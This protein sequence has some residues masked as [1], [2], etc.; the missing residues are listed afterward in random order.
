M[1]KIVVLAFFLLALLF[2]ACASAEPEWVFPENDENVRFFVL[3]ASSDDKNM[4]IY[5]MRGRY[6]YAETDLYLLNPATGVCTRLDFTKYADDEAAIAVIKERYANDGQYRDKNMDELLPLLFDRENTSDPYDYLLSA[7]HRSQ[8]TLM[9]LRD[10]Y[11]MIMLPDYCCVIVNLKTGEAYIPKDDTRALGADGTYITWDNTM[12]YHF[13]PGDELIRTY[14]PELPEG[15]SVS[16]ARINDDGSLAICAMSIENM[17]FNYTFILTDSKGNAEKVYPFGSSRL[18]F[19]NILVSS[20]NDTY[21][22]FGKSSVLYYPA[23]FINTDTD[24]IN[25]LK[26][27]SAILFDKYVYAAVQT[28]Y[29]SEAEC[30]T[31]FIPL[32]MTDQNELIALAVP[33]DS[34]LIKINLDTNEVT[35]LLTGIQWREL[36][37]QKSPDLFNHS[38][39]LLVSVQSH[40]GSGIL[41]VYPGGAIR[42]EP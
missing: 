40:N 38:Q 3:T 32:R 31:K 18:M 27:D 30:E 37:N 39:T 12:V 4:L 13:G 17:T 36:G 21:V 42:H 16:L 34:D 20:D 24:A 2:C 33:S 10:D 28:A 19:D 23:Y 22:V 1:K 8:A 26:M 14:L 9:D 7:G 25:M 35:V 6:P 11:A 41:S 15:T 29:D 5:T